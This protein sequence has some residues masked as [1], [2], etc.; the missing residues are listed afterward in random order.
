MRD[1][2]KISFEQALLIRNFSAGLGRTEVEVLGEMGL[3]KKAS[4]EVIRMPNNPHGS[5]EKKAAVFSSGSG[6]RL[7]EP[8]PFTE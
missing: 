6:M 2:E 8:V 5:E 4:C 3:D 7:F 1:F